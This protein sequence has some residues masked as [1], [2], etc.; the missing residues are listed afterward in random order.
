MTFYNMKL[1]YQIPILFLIL[2]T[3]PSCY[4][5]QET[6]SKKSKIIKNSKRVV[7]SEKVVELSARPTVR[8]PKAEFRLYEQQ[9][10]SYQTHQSSTRLHKKSTIS[11]IGIVAGGTGVAGGF[12]LST[13]PGMRTQGL[14]TAAGSGLIFLINSL[15]PNSRTT[16]KKGR[17]PLKYENIRVPAALNTP[18]TAIVGAKNQEYLTGSEGLFEINMVKDFN[19]TDFEMD[20]TVIVKFAFNEN[21]L[22][23]LEGGSFYSFSTSSWTNRFVQATTDKVRITNEAGRLIKYALP[24]VKYKV[25]DEAYN[26][27]ELEI[28]LGDSKT[29]LVDK[30]KVISSWSVSNGN[31]EFDITEAIETFVKIRIRRWAVKDEFETTTDYNAR[32]L[33]VRKKAKVFTEEAMNTYQDEHIRTIDWSDRKI[34]LYDADR[35]TYLVT[36]KNA[37]EFVLRVPR[38]NARYFKSHFSTIKFKNEEFKLVNGKWELFHVDVY[39]PRM[40][41]TYK[42][43]NSLRAEYDPVIQSGLNI[44]NIEIDLRNPQSDPVISSSSETLDDYNIENHLPEPQNRN[45]PAFALVIGNKNY[46]KV[47]DVEYAINDAASVARYLKEVLGYREAEVEVIQNAKSNDFNIWFGKDLQ[48]EAKLEN[49]VTRN[50]DVF[51]FYSGHGAPSLKDQSG[52]F[53]PVDCDP[54]YLESSGY[55]LDQFYAR[56]GRIQ[57]KSKTVILDACFSGTNVY[58]NI[59]PVIIRTKRTVVDAEKTLILSSSSESQVSSWYQQKRHG[60][61]TYF[62]LKA[63]HDYRH[64]DYNQD[65]KLTFSEIYQYISDDENGVPF[66]ARRFHGVEQKPQ[67]MGPNIEEVLFKYR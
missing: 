52:Y 4:T 15:I 37:G 27:R 35:E 62:F 7:D 8:S 46:Q 44:E 63:I 34:S 42:Y 1:K 10:V 16:Y 22:S 25:S 12:L 64:S 29:G 54:Q 24:G 38:D 19:F 31:S 2:A 67:I 51:I 61:F 48:S 23:K 13:Q 47:D 33:D 14:M 49:Y 60:M 21:P 3:L 32:M 39:D 50:H 66:F 59:S 57:A 11:K 30:S 40:R 45:S 9:K 55:P 53:V 58:E 28:D 20:E 56:L 5:L 18:I 65:G 6:K 43:D 36:V 26:W 17:G 41:K